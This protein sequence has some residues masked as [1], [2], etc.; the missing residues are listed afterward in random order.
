M[1]RKKMTR[2]CELNRD[3]TGNIP[4]VKCKLYVGSNFL[5][6]INA[7]FKTNQ[8]SSAMFSALIMTIIIVPDVKFFRTYLFEPCSFSKI[9]ITNIIFFLAVRNH[10]LA[11]SAI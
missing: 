2:S 4:F 8:N 11:F 5:Q 1:K 9:Y 7:W 3:F 10:I 6:V